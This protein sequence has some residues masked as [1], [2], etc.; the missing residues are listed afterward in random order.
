MPGAGR[1]ADPLKFAIGFTIGVVPGIYFHQF[2]AGVGIGLALGVA[3]GP[4][5]ADIRNKCTRLR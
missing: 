2:A 4:I 5:G 3:L 1:P